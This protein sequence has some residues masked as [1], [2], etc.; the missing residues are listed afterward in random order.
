M[1]G[2]KQQLYLRIEELLLDK[3]R[4]LLLKAGVKVA[5]IWLPGDEVVQH[6]HIKDM[7]DAHNW[8]TQVHNLW[9]RA[10]AIYKMQSPVVWANYEQLG[11]FEN[12]R[13]VL[14][15]GE[16]LV[17]LRKAYNRAKPLLMKKK[18]VEKLLAKEKA[19]AKAQAK[20]HKET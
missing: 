10:N 3:M 8:V 9:L 2:S 6:M 1:S 18:H 12:H 14:I 11:G 19:R 13:E 4:F 20:T 7:R 17:A 5:R 16:R 15:L